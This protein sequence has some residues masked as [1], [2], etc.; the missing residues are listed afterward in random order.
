[1]KKYADYD[2][3]QSEYLLDYDRRRILNCADTFQSLAAVMG[4]MNWELAQ[5]EEEGQKTDREQRLRQLQAFESRRQYAAHMRQMAGFM[6][7]VAGTSVQLIRLG[8]RQERQIVRALAGEDIWVQDIYLLRGQ[9]DKLEISVSLCTKEDTSVTAAEIAGYLSVLMDI[10][11]VPEKRNPYFVGKEPVSLYFEEEPAF[12]CLTAAATAV[13]E[14]ETVSGDSYSFWEEDDGV[15]MILSDGVGSGECAARD[16]GRIVDLT[17]RILDAGLGVRMAV[18]LLDGMVG[19]EGDERRMSTL[20]LCRIDLKKATCEMIKAGGAAT[21]IKRG[22]SV[23]KISAQQLP[24]GMADD[25]KLSG[26]SRQLADGDM[27]VLLSDGVLQNWPAGD[28]EYL[29]ARKLENTRTSSPV[30]LANLLL[31]YAIGQCHGKIQDDMTVLVAGIWSNEER[32]IP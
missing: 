23:E 8:G 1:M 22:S 17:E 3:R 28:G 24:L 16:S 15:T 4:E 6:Q 11:L 21:F 25:G 13:E 18:Q 31:R 30:D 5:E 12:C 2:A 20:D 19:A 27:V 10:R 9:E 32:T 26:S 7:S 29:I 14:N